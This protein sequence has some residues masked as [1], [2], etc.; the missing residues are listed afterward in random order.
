MVIFGDRDYLMAKLGREIGMKKRIC[1]F[2]V[3][4]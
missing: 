3:K 1:G 2:L 4:D